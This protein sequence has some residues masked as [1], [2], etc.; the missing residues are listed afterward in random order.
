[1]ERVRIIDGESKRAK[2]VFKQLATGEWTQTRALGVILK[3][4]EA[5]RCPSGR[6]NRADALAQLG[7][8]RLVRTRPNSPSPR[9]EPA[10]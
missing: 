6:V 7:I 2:A 9:V 3:V 10:S 4:C 8:P 5:T 1:M